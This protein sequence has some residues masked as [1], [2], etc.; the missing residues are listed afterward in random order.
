MGVGV[1]RA[2]AGTA[3]VWVGENADAGLEKGTRSGKKKGA[4]CWGDF[5]SASPPAKRASVWVPRSVSLLFIQY[6][7]RTNTVCGETRCGHGGGIE[8]G[9]GAGVVVAGP[10]LSRREELIRTTCS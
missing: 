3:L 9:G 5:C 7:S 2:A 8:G 10:Y 6:G 1:G 4:R